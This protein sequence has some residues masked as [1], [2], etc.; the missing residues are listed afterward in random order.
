[1]TFLKPFYLFLALVALQ[2]FP[3]TGVFLMMVAGPLITG[4]AAHLVLVLMAFDALTRRG[5]VWLLLFPALF[6]GGH[7]LR[8]HLQ[9]REIARVSSELAATNP[10]RILDFDPDRQSLVMKDAGGFVNTHEIP[11]AYAENGDFPPEGYLSYRL[12]PRVQCNAV[13]KD[14]Q[15]R[16]QTWGLH[17]Y[18]EFVKDACRLQFPEAP[19]HS[20][21]SVLVTP[22]RLNSGMQ[23]GVNIHTTSVSFEGKTLGVYRTGKIS[24]L[25]KFPWLF[26]GC[27]LNSAKPSWECDGGVMRSSFTI[28]G[29]PEGV[30]PAIYDTPVAIMLGIRKYPPGALKDFKG[31]PQ[32]S[33][34]LQAVEQDRARVEDNVFA[35][36]ET[37]LAG[38]AV[39][40]TYNLG[41]AL[42]QNPA[43]LEAYA[44]RMMRRFAELEAADPPPPPG[45][46]NYHRRTRRDEPRALATAISSLPPQAFAPLA[47]RILALA[48]RERFWDEYASLYLR[49]ADVGP[50]AIEFYK[51][52]F[53]QRRVEPRY[54]SLPVLALCRIGAADPAV[55][56]EMK[57]QYILPDGGKSRADEVAA[58]LFLALLKFGETEFLRTNEALSPRR[59]RL[60]REALL[61]GK[62]WNA[63]GPNNCMTE[64][65]PGGYR[66]KILAPTLVRVRNG[67][68]EPPK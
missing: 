2:L 53:L 26:I 62:G 64:R 25:P 40:K 33:D 13:K 60:W 49:A 24:R 47:E 34:V 39:G 38:G 15:S 51:A 52:D 44:E 48:Q 29:T 20:V 67:W 22:D 21:V 45:E 41:Y 56:E 18:R 1:M 4:L 14:T 5:P 57:A 10:K 23:P 30:D 59:D 58:A 50:P 68:D 3:L 7:Y 11:A 37:V 6:Y 27:A 28:E 35:T 63:V 16:I 46:K 65:W 66:P 43:R 36:L 8:Y 17:S 61:S 9:E 54:A 32:N 42:E 12:I 19:P 31:Y 55:V